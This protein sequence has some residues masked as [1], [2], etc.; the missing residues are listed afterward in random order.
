MAK[1]SKDTGAVLVSRFSALGDVAIAIPSLYDACRSNPDRHF[2]MLTRR[3]PATL[4]VNPPANLTVVGI[5]TA[6]YDGLAGLWR[7]SG[8]LQEKYGFTTY[9]DLHDVLRTQ[10]LRK[11]MKMRG[12]KCVK[13]IRKG[14]RAK[15]ALTRSRNKVLLQL[16]S[17]PER[18]ADVYRRTGITADKNF[19]SIFGGIPADPTLF[20]SIV[21]EPKRNGE[22]WIAIAPFAA[23]EGKIYPL[24]LMKQVVSHYAL[25]PDF[26]VFLFGA[27]EKER[28]EL[29]KMRGEHPRVMNMA[30]VRLGIPGELALLSHCDVMLSM[31]SAN[32]HLASLAGIPA[33]TVWGATHPFTGFLGWR[34]SV[35]DAVQLDMVCRPCSVFGNRPC[36]F[37][38]YHC[39]H[40]IPPQHIIE[41]IDSH[42]HSDA[43]SSASGKR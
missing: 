13:H 42:L 30:A 6:D 37:G 8:E 32:M 19:V 21:L 40:G 7:L 34:Q 43:R 38:D 39:L 20:S 15:K 10:L 3:H 11:F 14:R 4:F 2:V 23:H 29:E 17:T 26:R 16:P 25:R 24:G 33:V 41:R 1:S 28:E 22:R 12:V 9:V 35:K 5:D 31:D 18:Y 27:G 36:R